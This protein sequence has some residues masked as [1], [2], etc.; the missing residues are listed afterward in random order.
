[1]LGEIIDMELRDAPRMADGF[2]VPTFYVTDIV[3]EDAG[4][5]N[6]RIWNCVLKSGLLMPVCEVIVPASRLLRIG[7][8]ASDFA[9]DLHQRQQ[10]AEIL[11]HAGARH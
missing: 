3:T 10:M 7:R 11:E 6:V 2:G 4:N 1:L 5:G 9:M 8:D